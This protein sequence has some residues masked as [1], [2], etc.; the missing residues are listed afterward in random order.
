MNRKIGL[1]IESVF[2]G[3]LLVSCSNQQ[4]PA[5]YDAIY[6]ISLDRTPERFAKTKKLLKENGIEANRF[7]AVDGYD[8]I[9]TNK[10]TGEVISGKEAM[11]NI[12]E[13]TW[14]RRPVFYH[15]SYNGKYK[16][17]EFDLL[18]QDRQFSAGEIGVAYSHRA[19][20]SDVVKNHYS[21]V[22]VFEDDMVPLKNFKKNLFDLLNNI[23]ND[24]DVVFISIGQRKDKSYYYPCIDKIFRDF[25]KVPGNEFVAKIQATNKVYGMFAYIIGESGAQKL[26]EKSNSIACPIDDIVLSQNAGTMNLYVAKKKFCSVIFSGSEI[27]KMGRS[28]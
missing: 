20:W 17:S 10:N 4:A 21:R 14:N 12:R 3:F 22:L 27:K 9:L 1:I 7:Q 13:Y 6:V 19:I 28:F 2:V 25:D 24:A 5:P 16:E 23:P 15:V 26:L 11:S 18:V 8:I